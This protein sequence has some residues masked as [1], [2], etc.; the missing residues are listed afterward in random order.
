MRRPAAALMTAVAAS[1]CA[2]VAQLGTEYR[3]VA[4]EAGSPLVDGGANEDTST[5]AG[6]EAHTA[7]DAP[8]TPDG[9]PGTP[10]AADASTKHDADPNCGALG[11][12]D[13]CDSFDNG[14]F[15]ARWTSLVGQAGE[16]SSPTPVSPPFC[17]QFSIGGATTDSDLYMDRALPPERRVVLS[18]QLQLDPGT[19]ATG[20]TIEVAE[21][22]AVDG[23]LPPQEIGGATFYVTPANLVVKAACDASRT[24]CTLNEVVMITNKAGWHPF[25]LD[26]TLGAGTVT[27]G[28]EAY[29]LQ[30]QGA[31]VII[32]YSGPVA[33]VR[34]RI[35]ARASAAS[36]LVYWDDVTIDWY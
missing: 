26:V 8:L 10:D 14:L 28:W 34:T 4:D 6:D 3:G 30:R 32:A 31:T 21:V 12:H 5:D 1:G 33:G 29:G 13:F 17:A 25:R 11:P 27:V 16:A 18:G 9:A 35:G 20:S 2:L 15:G 36:A 19:L 24:V 7:P 23:S 22:V